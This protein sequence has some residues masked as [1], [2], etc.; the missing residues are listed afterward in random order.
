MVM[1]QLTQYKWAVK[2]EANDVVYQMMQP[3]IRFSLDDCADLPDQLFITRDVEMTVEQKKAYKD[4][5]SKLA[6]IG[7]AHV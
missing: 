5:L 6:K 7:R 4:M 1:R 2:P 3:S